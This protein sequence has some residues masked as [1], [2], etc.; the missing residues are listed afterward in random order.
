VW[1]GPDQLEVCVAASGVPVD[2]LNP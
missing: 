2:R 1:S